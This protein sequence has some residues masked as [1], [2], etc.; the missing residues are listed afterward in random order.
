MVEHGFFGGIMYYQPYKEEMRGLI[1]G[2]YGIICYLYIGNFFIKPLALHLVIF[3]EIF[4]IALTEE[5]ATDWEWFLLIEKIATQI[6]YWI[7]KFLSYAGK[8]LTRSGS[9]VKYPEQLVQ[10]IFLLPGSV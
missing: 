3:I 4:R 2:D 1:E 7:T 10:L 8:T 6:N 5:E 9:D